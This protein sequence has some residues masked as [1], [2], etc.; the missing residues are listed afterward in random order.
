MLDE[1][2]YAGAVASVLHA[3]VCKWDIPRSGTR[4]GSGSNGDIYTN[5]DRWG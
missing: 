5:E 3:F 2:S 1:F 4:F